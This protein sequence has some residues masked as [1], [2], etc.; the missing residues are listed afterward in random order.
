MNV[1]LEPVTVENW[2]D[3]IALDIAPDQQH[4]VPSN[5]YSIAEAQFYPEATSSA[6]FNED[7]QLVGYALFGREVQT[8]KWKIFRIMI[9]QRH[10]NKG[11]GKAAMQKIIATIA[12]ESDGHEILIAYQTNNQTARNLYA[13]LGFHEQN[14]DENGKVTALLT[15]NTPGFLPNDK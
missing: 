3:C 9:D 12:Q 8:Q 13:T 2:K 5:L 7:N 10:Q 4:F 11:Y 15:L 6:I 14:M 1:R